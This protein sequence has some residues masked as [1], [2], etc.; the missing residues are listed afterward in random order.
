LWYSPVFGKIEL[1]LIRKGFMGK[2]LKAGTVFWIFMWCIFM[3]ITVG[4]IGIGAVFPSVNRVTKPFVC[5]DG[6]LELVTQD[7]HPSPIETDTT[8]TW[9]CVD[10]ATG[11]R[12]EVSLFKMAF[13][14]GPLYGT[15]LFCIV[16]EFLW[17]R[18]SSHAQPATAEASERAHL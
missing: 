3:G 14:A 17:V 2:R 10:P 6:Q 5:N 18:A 11:A 12:Q 1:V 16:M 9:Y 15:V 13:I 7:Y 8:L 4:S